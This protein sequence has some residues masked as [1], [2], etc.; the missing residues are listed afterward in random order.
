M[1]GTDFVSPIV[2]YL[3]QIFQKNIDFLLRSY[4][5]SITM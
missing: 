2:K 5:T 3:P 4:I 1:I